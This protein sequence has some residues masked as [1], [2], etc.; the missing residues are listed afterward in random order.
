M[1]QIEN[2]I[3]NQTIENQEILYLLR[4][5]I[6]NNN[7]EIV[8]VFNWKIPYYKYKNKGLCYLNVNKKGKIELGFVQGYLLID[9]HS[10][11]ESLHL[12]QIR[13]LKFSEIDKINFEAIDNFIHQSIQWIDNK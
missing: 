2:Y 8:E 11:L 6:I 12:K 3:N 7:A 10:R 9:E 5:I 1:L 13:H 4:E